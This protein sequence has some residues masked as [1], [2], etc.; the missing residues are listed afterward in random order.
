MALC[1]DHTQD[2]SGAEQHRLTQ[3]YS[4]PDFVKKASHEQLCGG[5][6]RLPSHVFGSV[7]RRVYPCHTKAATWLSALFFADKQ[8]QLP[9]DEA[10]IVKSRLLKSAAH[11]SIQPAVEALWSKMAADA[12]ACESQLTDD[13]FAMV[14]TTDA[15]DTERHYPL[16]NGA[17]VKMASQWFDINHSEF[18]FADKNTVASKILVK[19]AAYGVTVANPELLDRCAGFGACSAAMAA[20]AW[21]KRAQLV[22]QSRPD[23]AEQ[24]LQV[25]QSLRSDMPLFRERQQRVKL[26]SLLDQFDRQTA[27][28][29]LYD[30]GGLERP[31]DALFSITEKVA[32][33]FVD[34]HV[35]TTTGAVYEKTALDSLSITHVRQWLG[36]AFADEVGGVMLDTTK[37]AALV[38][39]LPRPAAAMFERMAQAAGVPSIARDKSAAVSGLS[40]DDTAALAAEYAAMA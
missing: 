21:E 11:W 16:R 27:L 28:H 18:T 32:S 19:A 35:Q 25:A 7:G 22:R 17:E 4:P 14:W 20:D 34:D 6:E 31:E 33:A 24:A 10:E 13:D 8:G 38:P 23:Y 2:V 1:L 37:L 36:D 5:E 29:R 26:A 39:T 30:D 12:T 40:D 9:A 15:G 3:L